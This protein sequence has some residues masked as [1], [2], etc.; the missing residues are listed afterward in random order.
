M[1]DDMCDEYDDYDPHIA[2]ISRFSSFPIARRVARETYLDARLKVTLQ[3][4]EVLNSK[5]K[6]AK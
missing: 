2:H 4:C 1:C 3:V 6:G 5:P